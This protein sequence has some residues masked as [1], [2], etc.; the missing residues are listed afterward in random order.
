[1][2][3]S[4]YCTSDNSDPPGCL[5]TPHP[6]PCLNLCIFISFPLLLIS[7]F[8]PLFYIRSQQWLLHL[9]CWDGPTSCFT[10]E[11]PIRWRVEQ[12]CRSPAISPRISPLPY[13]FLRYF[14][15]PQAGIKQF[16]SNGINSLDLTELTRLTI[17]QQLTRTNH[18][19]TRLQSKFIFLC[20][21]HICL[22]K[23]CRG[24]VGWFPSINYGDNVEC[25]AELKGVR[26]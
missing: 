16:N 26:R 21:R 17:H 14:A 7:D 18:T 20:F 8:L 9:P 19:Q 6:A 15:P 13:I 1:M 22:F 24:T 23:A 12:T 5:F 11:V 2:A 10:R 25:L 4:I 3:S